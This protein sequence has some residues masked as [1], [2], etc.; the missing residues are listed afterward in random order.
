MALGICS[1]VQ[2][3]CLEDSLSLSSARLKAGRGARTR[4][5]QDPGRQKLTEWNNTEQVIVAI[6]DEL[7][8]YL[9]NLRAHPGDFRCRAMRVLRNQS[10]LSLVD[11]FYFFVYSAVSSGCP[12][13]RNCP[14]R[15]Q[16]V[17]SPSPTAAPA[18]ETRCSMPLG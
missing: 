14:T 10:S 5:A 16:L 11:E 3:C 7:A 2:V 13:S 8:K 6:D 18:A 4:P 15:T 17:F 9:A 1:S 12:G